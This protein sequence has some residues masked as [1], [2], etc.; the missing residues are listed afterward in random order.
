VSDTPFNPLN[1]RAAFLASYVLARARAKGSGMDGASVAR[2]AIDALRVIEEEF[3][4]TDNKG[5][6]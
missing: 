6:P 3:S 1:H 2:E 5:K 4:G